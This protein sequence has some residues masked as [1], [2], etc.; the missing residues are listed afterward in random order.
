MCY[1]A[2]DF[3]FSLATVFK[4]MDVEVVCEPIIRP[5][6]FLIARKQPMSGFDVSL[7]EMYV[8]GTT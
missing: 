7:I 6:S 2:T 8:S 5:R 4:A 3:F 1:A